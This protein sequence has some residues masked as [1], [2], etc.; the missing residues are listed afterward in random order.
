[1]IRR[2]MRENKENLLLPTGEG[3]ILEKRKKTLP[4]IEVDNE[5][6]WSNPDFPELPFPFKIIL[7]G[8]LKFT[9]KILE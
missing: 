1:M 8:L 7:S 5:V 6:S 3:S 2:T 9:E 4:A